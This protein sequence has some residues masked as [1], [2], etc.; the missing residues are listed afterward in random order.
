[1]KTYSLELVLFSWLA[2]NILIEITSWF[3]KDEVELPPA[4]NETVINK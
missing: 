2:Y 3:D 1:M 4:V